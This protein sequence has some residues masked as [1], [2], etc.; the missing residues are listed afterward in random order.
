MT[1]QLKNPNNIHLS[2]QNNLSRQ[3]SIIADPMNSN[4]SQ[5]LL[6]NID[7]N[8]DKVKM[9]IS[10]GFAGN[11]LIDKEPLTQSTSSASTSFR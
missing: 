3:N 4:K 11:Y 5:I 8:I 1:I 6:Q 10:S 9:K 2:D 7:K